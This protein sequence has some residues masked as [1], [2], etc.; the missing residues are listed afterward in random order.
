M[1]I[2]SYF[3]AMCVKK[4]ISMSPTDV[5]VAATGAPTSASTYMYESG[6]YWTST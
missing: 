4:A 3:V 5:I 6:K 2:H 1:Y